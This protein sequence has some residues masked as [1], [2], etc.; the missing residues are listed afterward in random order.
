[1]DTPAAILHAVAE[2]FLVN[3]EPD[4]IHT[5]H[6]GASLVVSESAGS[7]SSAFLHQA[8]L[9]RLI[10]SNNTARMCQ[11]ASTYMEVFVPLSPAETHGLV[12]QGLI[13][14]AKLAF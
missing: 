12:I 13:S 6:G 5:L 2:R 9:H 8:L 11:A 10:H 3:I 14:C 4:V 7:L 1:M